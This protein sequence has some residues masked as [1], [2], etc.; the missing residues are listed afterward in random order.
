MQAEYHGFGVTLKPSK[1]T[2][3]NGKAIQAAV[4]HVLYTPSF[5]VRQLSIICHHQHRNICALLRS[6]AT[7]QAVAQQS[8]AGIFSTIAQ[9]THSMLCRSTEFPGFMVRLRGAVAS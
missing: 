2:P 4:Q 5:M 1:L 3:V 6:H 8:E 9:Y 7:N